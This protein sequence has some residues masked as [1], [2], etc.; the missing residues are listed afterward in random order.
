MDEMRKNG[1]LGGERLL[2]ANGND[3]PKAGTKGGLR[4]NFPTFHKQVSL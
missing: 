2:H 1:Q 4:N 3:Q